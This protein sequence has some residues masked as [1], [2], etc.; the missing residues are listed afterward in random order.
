MR[1]FQPLLLALLT[2]A[3]SAGARPRPSSDASATGDARGGEAAPDAVA[4]QDLPDAPLP[5]DSATDAASTDAR[6][7]EGGGDTTANPCAPRPG[8]RFCD[9]FENPAA[10]ATGPWAKSVNGDGTVLLD[11]ATPAHSG[12]HAVHV[13]GTGFS[14]FLVFHD[15]AVLPAPGGRFYLRLFLRLAA[16]MTGGHNTFFVADT[17]AAPGA[18]NAVRVGEMNEMLMLTVS[19]DT[20]GALSNENYYNDHRPGVV[21]PPQ[22]WSCVEVLFD[23]ARPEL[24]VWVDGAEVADLHRTAWPLDSYDAIRLGFEKYAGPAGDLWYDDVAI[25]TERIGCQ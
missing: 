25:S 14:T 18:G 16:P 11:S 7:N 23:A 15:P 22:T 12:S 6:A 4:R 10:F 20:H 19:G 8:L 2:A 3:C 13:A 9:D 1:P 5:P 21:F 24:D 17:A